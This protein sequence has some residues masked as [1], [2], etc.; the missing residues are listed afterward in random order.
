MIFMNSKGLKG[1]KQTLKTINKDNL[2]I[3]YN[4]KYI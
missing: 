4:I 2:K 3:K 1:Y